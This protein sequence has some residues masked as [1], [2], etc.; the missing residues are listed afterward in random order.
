M[1]QLVFACT[2]IAVCSPALAQKEPMKLT[3]MTPDELIWMP[4]PPAIPKGAQAAA[5]TGDPTKAGS[6]VVQRVK[7][8]P[9]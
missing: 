6:L 9:N 1:K 5:L 7:F 4:S 3:R 8:P 2:M